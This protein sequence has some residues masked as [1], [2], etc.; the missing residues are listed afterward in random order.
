MIWKPHAT[1]AAIVERDG[2]YLMVEE[3][4]DGCIVYNQPAGHL[5]PGENLIQ[6]AVRETQ[7]ET[8]WL[9]KP[10]ALVGIYVW[11]QP[12]TERTFLRFAFCGQCSQ[13]DKDQKLDDGI[14]RALWLSK[15]ELLQQSDKLRSPLV[16]E[17]IN[18][19]QQGKRYPLDL[20]SYIP[21]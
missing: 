19:Y 9:F 16:L 2:K 15:D 3:D 13:H 10:E 20:L 21:N 14:L 1:V 18:D 4:A 5:D 11:D 17:C 7:E 6:A 8:A 12:E